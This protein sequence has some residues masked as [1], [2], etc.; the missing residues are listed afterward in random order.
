[1]TAAPHLPSVVLCGGFATWA[2]PFLAQTLVSAT[3]TAAT[4]MVMSM[5]VVGA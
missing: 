2:H 3:A 4:T 1:M 5:P